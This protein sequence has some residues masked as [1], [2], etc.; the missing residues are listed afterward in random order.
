[1]A[2]NFTLHLVPACELTNTRRSRLETAAQVCND[3][4][5]SVTPEEYRDFVMQAIE[6][7]SDFE[8]DNEVAKF[9]TEDNG[10]QFYATGGM[11][12]GDPATT[13][14]PMVDALVDCFGQ[15]LTQW[16]KADAA[17][18]LKADRKKRSKK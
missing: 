4:Y 18:E 2:A 17:A 7:Y 8:N 10:P 12:Y 1:M 6:A 16:A 14:A 9:R 13:I 5:D 3:P 15:E 11:S